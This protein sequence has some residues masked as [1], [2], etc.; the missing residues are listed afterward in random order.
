V[1]TSQQQFLF[2][3]LDSQSREYLVHARDRNGRGIPGWFVRCPN[4]AP[5]MALI[6]GALILALTCVIAYRVIVEEPLGVAMFETAGLLLGGWLVLYALRISIAAHGPNYAGHF[7]LADPQTLWIAS[8]PKVTT[9]D[10]SAIV[11]AEGEPVYSKEGRYMNTAITVE[12]SHGQQVFSIQDRHDAAHLIAYFNALAWLHSQGD[13]PAAAHGSA[14]STRSK[15]PA[16]ILGG[17]AREL[18]RND[19]M[20]RDVSAQGLGLE[21]DELPRPQR[22]G[23]AGWG[24]LNCLVIG[25][26]AIV[27]VLAFKWLNV[28][29]RDDAVWEHINHIEDEDK[30]AP[31]LRAYVG[32]ARNTRH[33]DEAREM[34]KEIYDDTASRIRAGLIQ[35]RRFD[36]PKP[37]A[38]L[39]AAPTADP[40]LLDGLAIVLRELAEQPLPLVSVKVQEKGGAAEGKAQR[41]E[42]VL[43]AYTLALLQGVGEELVEFVKAPS[44]APGLIDITFSYERAGLDGH[45]VFNFSFRRTPSSDPAATVTWKAD[46]P[47]LSVEAVQKLAED[48]G[49]KTAGGKKTDLHPVDS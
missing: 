41:E 17:V 22:Q 5:L 19:T 28:G 45:Y 4:Y 3:E 15:L 44:D 33:H 18:A 39:N 36:D 43:K 2:E 27:C 48:L 40:R 9:N 7:V 29:W 49:R 35:R 13:A 32:D 31:W 11:G 16:P 24:I 47:W 8:G 21:I 42:A 34:L 10:I 12:T 23:R 14:K 25:G 26:A 6:G 1:S 30:R 38:P 20:P 46:G 37:V